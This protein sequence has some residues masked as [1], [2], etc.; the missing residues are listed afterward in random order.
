[1]VPPCAKC[2]WCSN[3]LSVGCRLSPTLCFQ[4]PRKDRQGHLTP[5]L[6][7]AFFHVWRVEAQQRGGGVSAGADMQRGNV[8]SLITL[9]NWRQPAALA[10]RPAFLIWASGGNL[11]PACD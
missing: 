2:L 5:L 8:L 3:L 1:M 9:P 10:A 4:I 6:R 7:P 11:I